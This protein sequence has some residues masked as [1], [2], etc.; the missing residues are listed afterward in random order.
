[1]HGAWKSD[2]SRTTWLRNALFHLGIPTLA[3]DF[4]GHGKSSQ[5]FSCS[6]AKR[7]SEARDAISLLDVNTSICLIGFSM[8]GE[9]SIQLTEYFSVQDLVLFAPWIYDKNVIEMSFDPL[10][11]QAIR[12]HESWKN[13]AIWEILSEYQW[14]MLLFTPELDTVIPEWVNEIIMNAAP[15]SQKERIIVKWAVHMMWNWMNEHPERIPE[16]A[17]KIKRLYI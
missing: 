6:I 12:A 17:E 5:N 2:I 13:T 16:I 15:K 1:M 11:T 14:N 3:I 4:S 7:V 8:S 10:F 9:V